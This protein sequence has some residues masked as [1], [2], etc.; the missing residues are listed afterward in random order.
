MGLFCV[1]SQQIDLDA[2]H[3]TSLDFDLLLIKN[4]Y[5]VIELERE[6]KKSKSCKG[7]ETFP[8]GHECYRWDICAQSWLPSPDLMWTEAAGEGCPAC[9][10]P[11]CSSLFECPGAEGAAEPT[12]P[13]PGT[14]GIRPHSH[15][16]L[17]FSGW[18]ALWFF[19]NGL[20]MTEATENWKKMHVCL[21]ILLVLQAV[22]W[23]SRNTVSNLLSYHSWIFLVFFLFQGAG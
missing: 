5:T 19:A 17:S 7:S 11:S 16:C 20:I 1:G 2:P 13:V 18:R 12:F 21:R 14:Y 10:G 3:P 22:L 15:Y 4:S 9:V 23:Q 6:R 8:L